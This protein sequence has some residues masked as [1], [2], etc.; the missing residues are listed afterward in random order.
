MQF[1]GKA[2]GISWL[3]YRS[4]E[5]I[6]SYLPT[7]YF[8]HPL[9]ANKKRP[10]TEKKDT[11][12]CNKV[13]GFAELHNS[14]Q[15]A[16]ASSSRKNSPGSELGQLIGQCSGSRNSV[17]LNY[18]SIR[19]TRGAKKN[20]RGPRRAFPLHA[21]NPRADVIRTCIRASSWVTRPWAARVHALPW[22]RPGSRE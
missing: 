1:L 9:C 22:K 11:R 12:R 8:M 15:L 21:G 17:L 16:R 4:K 7:E 13:A 3:K 20:P 6:I 14:L 2:Y 10:A 18:A 19:F 5:T